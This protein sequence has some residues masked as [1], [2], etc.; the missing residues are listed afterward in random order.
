MEKIKK[1]IKIKPLIILMIVS[2]LFTGI[3][4]L[5]SQGI[6]SSVDKNKN[7]NTLSSDTKT[8]PNTAGGNGGALFRGMPGEDE[9]GDGK[10]PAPGPDV[11][12]DPIGE[13]ILFLSFLSGCYAVVRRKM[14]NKNEK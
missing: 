9:T 3:G 6:Y 12:E 1:M 11:D 8:I 13:G 10:D 4:T 2:F 14:K 7:K 5:R